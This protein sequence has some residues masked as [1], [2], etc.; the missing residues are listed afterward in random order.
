MDAGCHWAI[1]DHV[2]VPLTG[3]PHGGGPVTVV[4]PIEQF[5]EEVPPDRPHVTRLVTYR[6]RCATC[7]AV[8][9]SHPLQ[10]STATGAAKARLGPYAHALVA[11]LPLD[12][13]VTPR[14]QRHPCPLN[15]NPCSHGDGQDTSSAIHAQ[16]VGMPPRSIPGNQSP[17]RG[18]TV[19]V[20]SW[21]SRRITTWAGLPGG[22]PWAA[23]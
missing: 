18:V 15:T 21:P 6:G 16:D 12:A 10:T 1:P 13:P 20:F 2:E 23:A 19:S 4:E 17:S 9:S 7:G 14:P 8:P 5:I 3:S 22:T 11:C